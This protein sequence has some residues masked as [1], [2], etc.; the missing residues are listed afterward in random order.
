MT[1]KGSVAREHCIL[2][3]LHGT[4]LPLWAYAIGR[5]VAAGA[6][7]L[8]SLLAI[9]AVGG[10][11]LYVPL[12]ASVVLRLAG[13]AALG[14]AAFTTVALAAITAIEPERLEILPMAK[15]RTSCRYDEEAAAWRAT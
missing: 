2:K 1:A 11:F 3:R 8:A 9:F 13:I 6:V 14:I 10:L 4:P 12:D 5:M 7:C 15:R